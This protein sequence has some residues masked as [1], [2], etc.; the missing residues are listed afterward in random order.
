MLVV[1]EMM[2]AFFAHA[3][4]QFFGRY[5]DDICVYPETVVPS[6]PLVQGSMTELS[7][8]GNVQKNDSAV[9]LLQ[10]LNDLLCKIQLIGVELGPTTRTTGPSRAWI[11]PLCTLA[12][13]GTNEAP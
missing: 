9:A 13:S 10:Q 12:D 2:V 5:A 6:V 7:I 11:S 1:K 3:L 4:K 8:V